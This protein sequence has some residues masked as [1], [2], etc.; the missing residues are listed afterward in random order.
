[1][2]NEA[3]DATEAVNVCANHHNAAPLHRRRRDAN[4]I[5]L[6]FIGALS[7]SGATLLS[8][9]GGGGPETPFAPTQNSTQSSA[10]TQTPTPTS[11]PTPTPSPSN[12]AYAGV[13]SS[14]YGIDP[15]PTPAGWTNAMKTMAG[16]FNTKPITIWIVG[17]VDEV[18]TGIHLDFPSDGSTSDSKITFASED[19]HE[20]F[21]NYFDA[22]GISGHP[23]G[24]AGVRGCGQADRPRIETIWASSIGHWVRH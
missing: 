23:A 15:F 21:L 1:M 11:T 16:K 17:D 9:C 12:L 24:G 4:S 14:G 3:L 22:N 6:K 13:R 20:A 7:V 8:A 18:T 5:T 2:K 10:I 19:K